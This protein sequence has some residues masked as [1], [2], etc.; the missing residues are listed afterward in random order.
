MSSTS[1][2]VFV[3]AAGGQLGRLTVTACW[4][5]SRPIA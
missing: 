3:T 5:G 1:P 4:T 2:T